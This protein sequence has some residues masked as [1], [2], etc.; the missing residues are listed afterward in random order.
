MTSLRWGILSTGQI[1]NKMVEELRLDGHVVTA[2]GSRTAEKA[3]AFAARWGI[4]RA[5]GDYESLVADPEVD[6]VYIATPIG[7]HAANATLALAAGKHVLLEK[8]FTMNAREAIEITSLAQRQGLV[9]LEAMWTRFHPH[10]A[11]MREVLASGLLGDLRFVVADNAWPLIG[12]PSTERLLRPELGGGAMGDM[13]IY[14]LSLTFDVLGSPAAVHGFGTLTDTGVDRQ[15]TVVLQYESGAQ[16]MLVTA[17]DAATPRSATIV[18]TDARIQFDPYW[19]RAVGFSVLG[20]DDSVL[21]RFDQPVA[22]RGMYF[23]A[24]V[25]EE[26]VASGSTSTPILPPEQSVAVIATMDEIRRQ[27]GVRFPRD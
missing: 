14:P 26:L 13:G 5:H 20:K 25:L 15:T 23:Q 22:G 11:R 3:S 6:V 7:Q 17:L 10:M 18:G 12:G 1:A 8:A 4:P 24:R 16:A 2:V 19:Y 21:E 9:L 27:L